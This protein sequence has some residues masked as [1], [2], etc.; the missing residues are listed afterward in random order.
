MNEQNKENNYQLKHITDIASSLNINPDDVLCYGKYKAKIDIDIDKLQPNGKLILMTA[1][2]P[3][4]AGEGKTTMSIGLAD[5]LNKI[6]KKAS[7]ALRQPSLGPVFGIKGGATGGG[8]AEIIPMEDINLHFTGDIHAITSA[9]NLISAILE[10]HIFQGNTL[11][12]DES[13]ITWKRCVDMCDRSLKY[14]KENPITKRRT[15]MITAASEVMATF[16]MASSISDLKKRIANIVLAKNVNGKYITVKDLQADGAVVA[17]L[18]EAFKPNLAQTKEATPTFIHGGPFANIAHGC[19]SVVAT[20][21]AL[22]YSDFVVSEAGFAADLGAEK[23]LN[24]KCQSA[25][26]KPSLA[27]LVATVRALKLHGGCDYDDLGKPDLKTLQAGFCNMDK[28]LENLAKFGL[29]VVV[30]INQFKTDSDEEL[31]CIANYLASKNIDASISTA[32]ANGALGSVALANLVIQK[33]ENSKT[34]Y[35]PLYQSSLSLKDKMLTIAKEIYGAD[36]VEYTE[37]AESE[38]ASISKNGFDNL[39]VC[40]SKTQNSLSDNGKL[41]GR[42]T[43][44]TV[45]ISNV[46]LCNGA[47]FVV[48]VAGTLM[49]MP[50]L[51]TEP[52]S[53]FISVDDNGKIRGVV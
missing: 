34:N 40:V 33:I 15:F 6:G 43:G 16:C 46:K 11:Q 42:P 22:H 28:H 8:M 24:I 53:N 49:D 48:M 38:L 5:A 26:L 50:G 18:K 27:V 47:G 36:G 10:N 13:S 1:I 9:H 45:K 12:I 3:T 51:P 31:A 4:K 23:F 30:V 39:P 7:L 29:D 32:Y 44:F 25:N 35:K 2:T 19:N 52:R 14:D 41:L 20:K 37:A 21:M 17:L